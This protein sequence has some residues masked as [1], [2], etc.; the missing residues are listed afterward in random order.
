MPQRAACFSSEGPSTTA[1]L[2]PELSARARFDRLSHTFVFRAIRRLFDVDL[3]LLDNL[4][5][6]RIVA[7]LDV[8]EKQMKIVA[9][10]CFQFVV[11]ASSISTKLRVEGS[12]STVLESYPTN[13]AETV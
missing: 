1:R 4:R 10:V 2:L 13:P 9:T 6:I 12:T 3:L 5:L 11:C 8:H 7:L